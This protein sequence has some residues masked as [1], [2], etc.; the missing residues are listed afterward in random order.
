MGGYERMFEGSI[1]S[2][3]PGGI[4]P[5]IYFLGLIE[6]LAFV[7]LAVSLVKGEFLSDRS[8]SFYKYGLLVMTATFTMLS[9]ALGLLLVSLVLFSS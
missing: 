6:L 8:K 1:L 3:M 2:Q 7:L 9:F 5:F 4:P